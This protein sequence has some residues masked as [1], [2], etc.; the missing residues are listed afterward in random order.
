MLDLANCTLIDVLQLT[1]EEC[2]E[3]LIEAHCPR[4][5]ICSKCGEPNP[6]LITRRSRT[7]NLVSTL[8]KC[9]ACK[10]QFSATAG[11]IFEG[12][13]IP[14]NKWFGAVGGVFPAGGGFL[15]WVFPP[16]ARPD[17]GRRLAL[18]SGRSPV[19][20]PSCFIENCLDGCYS[21]F[22][23]SAAC[24]DAQGLLRVVR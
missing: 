23:V 12:S 13:K 18:V 16:N 15:I 22:W 8:F 9:R 24:G 7:K 20:S 17:R 4:G 21:P 14:L 1:P 3:I 2:R 6:N 11:P 5:P 10:R 19:E